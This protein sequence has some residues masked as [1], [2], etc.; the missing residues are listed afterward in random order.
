MEQKTEIMIQTPSWMKVFF[1]FVILGVLCF[2]GFVTWV[3]VKLLM[4]FKVI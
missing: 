3:I 1:V 4:F 2:L